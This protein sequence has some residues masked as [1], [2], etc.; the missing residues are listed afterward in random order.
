MRRGPFAECL[1]LEVRWAQSACRAQ[2]ICDAAVFLREGAILLADEVKQHDLRARVCALIELYRKP[3]PSLRPSV[4]LNQ[5]KKGKVDTFT[6]FT[7]ITPIPYLCHR[8]REVPIL[9]IEPASALDRVRLAFD[10]ERARCR[11]AH[12]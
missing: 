1:H 11:H 7:T 8:L 12:S 3:L 2:R 6:F 9:P 10:R 5:L 4:C